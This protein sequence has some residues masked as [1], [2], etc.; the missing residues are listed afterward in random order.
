MNWRGGSERNKVTRILIG[1]RAAILKIDIHFDNKVVFL[2]RRL[3]EEEF[4]ADGN[5]LGGRALE[6]HCRIRLGRCSE[7]GKR[8]PGRLLD[9]RTDRRVFGRIQSD[10][11]PFFGDLPE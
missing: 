3:L 10:A 1:F 2:L 8:K 9:E 11:L 6:L 5:L 7:F 4:F